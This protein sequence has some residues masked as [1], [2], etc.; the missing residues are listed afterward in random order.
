MD[1][2]APDLYVALGHLV[3]ALRQEVP[4]GSLG[5]GGVSALAA[6]ARCG[7]MRA[8]A[9]AAAEG[10]S[11]AG[12]T[13]VLNRLEGDGLAVRAPDPADGRAQLVSLTAEGARLIAEGS[14]VKLAALRRRLGGL[15]EAERRTLACAVPLLEKLA[16]D[17]A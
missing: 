9:L 6:L 7:P 4:S 11:A 15:T 3:R 17:V 1:D 12:M 10:L 8:S 16:D 14:E 5:A 2:L 13:R